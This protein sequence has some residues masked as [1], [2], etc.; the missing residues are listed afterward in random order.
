ML[1]GNYVK[2]K[3]HWTITNIYRRLDFQRMVNVSSSAHSLPK[4]PPYRIKYL[5]PKQDEFVEKS[6][7]SGSHLFVRCDLY[8]TSIHQWA[9]KKRVWRDYGLHPCIGR[10]ALN[11]ARSKSLTHYIH[12]VRS[13]G[14]YFKAYS[15]S[16]SQ[17]DCPDD[18]VELLPRKLISRRTKNRG[19]IE[20]GV[21][22]IDP[23]VALVPSYC[24]GVYFARVDFNGV[25]A[26][27]IFA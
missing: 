7:G 20:I 19:Q 9:Y 8:R 3:I 16:C 6:A 22:Q 15:Q 27:I 21:S 14:E 24:I 4:S 1:Y 12:V 13:C 17:Q 11:N 25:F 26:L 10:A 5:S 2:K 18:F 23:L